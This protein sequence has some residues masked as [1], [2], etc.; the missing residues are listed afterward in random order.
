MI[1]VPSWYNQPISSDKCTAL[2]TDCR[3]KA[4]GKAPFFYF[5]VK[6]IIFLKYFSEKYCMSWRFSAWCRCLHAYVHF[7]CRYMWK[8]V[9]Y[10]S[11][12]REEPIHH[13]LMHRITVY[14]CTLQ[15]LINICFGWYHSTFF[16]YCC[17][18]TSFTMTRTFHTLV[19]FTQVLK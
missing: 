6:N 12:E 13:I 3:K 11:A 9:C 17:R 18:M 5:Y 1:Y 14:H 2:R 15:C 10:I 4:F 8:H 19:F 7:T 16:L